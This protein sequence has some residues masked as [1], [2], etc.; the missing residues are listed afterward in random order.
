MQQVVR[1]R[2]G[3]PDVVSLRDAPVPAIGDEEVLV[4]VRAASV[5]AFDDHMLRGR[6]LLLRLSEGLRRPKSIALGVDLAGVVEAVGAAVDQL[7]P[8]D[9]VFGWRGGAFGEY[10]AAKMRSLVPKPANLTFEEAAAIPMAATTALQALRDAGGLRAGQ[11]VLVIGAGGGV[12]SFAVQLGRAL[13]GRVTATTSTPKLGA[14]AALGAEEV[15]DYTRIDVLRSGRRFDLILDV[16]GYCSAGELARALAPGGRA[17]GVGGGK[18]T[19]AGMA[20][21]M[22]S[23]AIR[24]RLGREGAQF[25]LAQMKRDDLVLLADLAAS[26]AIRPLVDRTFPLA[27]AAG[28]FRHLE[29]GRATGKVVLVV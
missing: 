11:S 17:V 2:Y 22:A 23:A 25:L 13:G 20:A 26:R 29:S 15:L 24:R 16:G 4:R 18:A 19:S 1:E 10:V 7:R 5:N 21:L 27:D 6:P 14:V 8:G 3:S 12:G 28:A 9:E